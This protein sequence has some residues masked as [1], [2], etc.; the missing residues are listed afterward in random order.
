M[1][2]LCSQCFHGGSFPF[3]QCVVGHAD[4]VDVLFKITLIL[5]LNGNPSLE[6]SH[7]LFVVEVNLV[8][9]LST[10]PCSILS[11]DEPGINDSVVASVPAHQFW[12][13]YMI[14]V[15]FLRLL[16]SYGIFF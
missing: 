14:F 15:F 9:S 10:F 3:C 16:I 7:N 12:F 6:L 1:V 4:I 11:V 13:V 8:R 2:S 5:R